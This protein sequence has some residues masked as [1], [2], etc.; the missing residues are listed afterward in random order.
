MEVL[1]WISMSHATFGLVV[2]QGYV[3]EA[4]PIAHWTLGHSITD[5]LRYYLRKKADI[6]I[7][8][9]EEKDGEANP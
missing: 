6:R 5:V 9:P 1:Y 7:I 3:A 4:P 8:T 2:R